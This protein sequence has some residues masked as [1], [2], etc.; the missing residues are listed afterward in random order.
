[1]SLLKYNI[2]SEKIH[3]IRDCR[4]KW[5]FKQTLV[6]KNKKLKRILSRIIQDTNLPYILQVRMF[7]NNV[8]L[9]ISDLSGVLRFTLSSGYN[10]YGKNKTAFMAVV[11]LTYEFLKVLNQLQYTKLFIEFRNCRFQRFAFLKSLKN[12]R[13]QLIV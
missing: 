9:H 5:E 2:I 7:R 10:F 6:W 1:M 3:K 11:T 8:F 12:F 4:S 13:N